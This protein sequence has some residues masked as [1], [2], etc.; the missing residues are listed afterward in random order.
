[1]NTGTDMAAAFDR[2]FE[3]DLGGQAAPGP[4]PQPPVEAPAAAPAGPAAGDTGVTDGQ[5]AQVEAP[6]AN[7][8]PGEGDPGQEDRGPIPYERFQQ[9]NTQKN[10]YQELVQQFIQDPKAYRQ[11]MISLTG[12]D[13]FAGAG[14]P[15]QAQP[16]DPIQQMLGEELTPDDFALE[17]DYRAYKQQRDL[18][19]T[20]VGELNTLKQ[21]QSQVQQERVSAA[22][23]RALAEFGSTLGD[24]EARMGVKLSDE[25][26]REIRTEAALY[27]DSLTVREAT[28]RAARH[29]LFDTAVSRGRSQAAQIRDAKQNIAHPGTV[30]GP[31]A[32]PAEGGSSL[33]AAFN[34]AWDQH[35]S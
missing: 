35:G 28:V 34:Q 32:A 14:Q 6:A 4:A 19:K 20:V 21:G 18:L 13:P 26:R 7:G 5:A 27:G 31:T 2:A 25:Q 24:I 11:A 3:S 30:G 16:Q 8:Q 1:M 22:R 12:Q 23:E 33:E 9:V 15:S 17:A 29:V 10:S